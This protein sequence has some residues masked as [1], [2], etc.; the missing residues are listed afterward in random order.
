MHIFLAKYSNSN[1]NFILG[2][3]TLNW[4]AGL[5]LFIVFFKFRGLFTVLAYNDF[6]FEQKIIF[7]LKFV[8]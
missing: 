8:L 3:L 7:H 4:R 2:L 5:N 1:L 6:F